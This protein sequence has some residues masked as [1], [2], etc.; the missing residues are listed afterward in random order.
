M[1]SGESPF[2]EKEAVWR[3][4]ERIDPEKADEEMSPPGKDPG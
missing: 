1:E 4:W 3:V 2:E